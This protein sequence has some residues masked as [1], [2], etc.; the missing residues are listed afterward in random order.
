MHAATEASGH[1]WSRTL[2][3]QHSQCLTANHSSS[4]ECKTAAVMEEAAARARLVPSNSDS[5]VLPAPLI[6]LPMAS[7]VCATDEQLHAAAVAAQGFEWVDEGKHG[8]HKWGYVATQPGSTLDLQLS[9]QISSS[10]QSSAGTPAAGAGAAAA[11]AQPGPPAAVVLVFLQ[12]YEHMGTANVSCVSGCTCT[13]IT[14]DAHRKNQ[15]SLPGLAQL[16][17]VSQH[18]RCVLRVTVGSNSS[19]GQHKFKVLGVIRSGEGFSGSQLGKLEHFMLHA[20]PNTRY[21]P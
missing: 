9:T 3:D 21:K 12:S 19:S 18:P 1:Q 8:T 4:M 7:S 14:I 11:A 10:N 20:E 6:A 5:Y 17:A 16:E 2:A 13:S 15:V